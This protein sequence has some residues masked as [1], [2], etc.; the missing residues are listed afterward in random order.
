MIVS[1]KIRASVAMLL[2]A[3]ALSTVSGCSAQAFSSDFQLEAEKLSYNC[4]ESVP[5]LTQEIEIIS[6]KNADYSELIFTQYSTTD[7]AKRSSDG[8]DEWAV[9]VNL[10]DQWMIRGEDADDVHSVVEALAPNSSGNEI[11]TV[12]YTS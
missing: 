8:F 3:G 9:A 7:A 1:T 2:I 4:V 6:R 5:T 12:T 11:G 10:G